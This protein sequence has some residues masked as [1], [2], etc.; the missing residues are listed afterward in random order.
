MADKEASILEKLGVSVGYKTTH[1]KT[2]TEAD[3]VLF[4][5]VSGDFNPVH[6]NEEYAKKTFFGGRIAHGALS[7][8]LLSAAMAKLPGLVIFLSQTLKFLKPVRIG[9]TITAVAEVTETRPDKGIVTL[10]NACFNQKGETVVE[11]EAMCRLY[12]P[13]A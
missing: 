5:G 2:I 6:V 4:A 10:K 3:I 11:G 1:S 9:D 13:P 7:Q 8:A 12:P